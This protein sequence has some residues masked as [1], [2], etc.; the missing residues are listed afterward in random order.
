AHNMVTGSCSVIVGQSSGYVYPPTGTHVSALSHK[1]P[2]WVA[3]S[4]VGNVNGQTVLNNEIILANTNPGGSVCRV[5]HHRSW[6]KLGPQGYWA[7]PHVVISPS[8]TRL[9]FG[10]DWGGGST[11]DAYVVE[12]PAYVP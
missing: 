11:V 8:A 3:V 12:L 10:S 7:E 6:G 1:N 2:G 9:L 4:M 5:A